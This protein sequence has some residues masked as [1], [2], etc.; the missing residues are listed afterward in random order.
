MNDLPKVPDGYFW[1][2]K[3][4]SFGFV[5][6]ELRKKLFWKFSDRIDHTYAH[7]DGVS[8]PE[9]CDY[10]LCLMKERDSNAAWLFDTLR[11]YGGDH[12]R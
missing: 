1:R 2:I 12:F 3:A 7:R 5:T 9:A 4:E 6:V 11:D 8:V 10:L